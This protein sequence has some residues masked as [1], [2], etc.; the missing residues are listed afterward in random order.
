MTTA[1]GL[2][3]CSSFASQASGFGREG[4]D[5]LLSPAAEGGGGGARGGGAEEEAQRGAAQSHGPASQ[6]GVRPGRRR[7]PVREH[8]D[9]DEEGRCDARGP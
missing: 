4:G 9:D 5:L 1:A 8:D 3:L 6:C 2:K 7:R